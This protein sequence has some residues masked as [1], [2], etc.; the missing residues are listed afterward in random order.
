MYYVGDNDNEFGIK[1]GDKVE[2]T[3]S[4]ENVTE[5]EY[6]GVCIYN[7]EQNID[8]ETVMSISELIDSFTPYEFMVIDEDIPKKPYEDN[9]DMVC[10]NCMEY[11]TDDFSNC[12]NCG[13]A[14]DWD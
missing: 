11:V 12:D 8:I 2:V 10:P 5:S 4:E 13:Q 14:L 1:Y 3:P 6:F 9:G 7:R